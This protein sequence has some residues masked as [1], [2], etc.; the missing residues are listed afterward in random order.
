MK[1]GAGEGGSV[2][3]GGSKVWGPLLQQQ[4]GSQTLTTVRGYK[5]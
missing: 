1:V 3:G 4:G 2:E 5:S